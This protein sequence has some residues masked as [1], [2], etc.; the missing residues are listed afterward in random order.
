MDKS[1]KKILL[2]FII[3]FSVF[4]NSVFAAENNNFYLQVDGEDYSDT[5][6]IKYVS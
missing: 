5:D 3:F 2:L 1:I 4:I 6:D